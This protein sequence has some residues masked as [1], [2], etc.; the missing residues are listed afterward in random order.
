MPRSSKGLRQRSKKVRRSKKSRRSTRRKSFRGNDVY[1]AHAGAVVSDSVRQMAEKRG[2]TINT[3]FTFQKD[4]EHVDLP[5][6]HVAVPKIFKQSLYDGD[7]L[8]NTQCG[9]EED[10]YL[11]WERG[12]DNNKDETQCKKIKYL[13]CQIHRTKWDAIRWDR[14]IKDKGK[15]RFFNTGRNLKPVAARVAAPV[16]T[17]AEAELI[18]KILERSK[19]IASQYKRTQSEVED[20]WKIGT[21][22]DDLD[23]WE[24]NVRRIIERS[25]DIASQY[26]STPKIV[27]NKWNRE[28]D[29]DLDVWEVNV[30]RRMVLDKLDNFMRPNHLHLVDSNLLDVLD[31]R[32][33][34]DRIARFQALYDEAETFDA[35]RVNAFKN[36][37]KNLA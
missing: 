26:K 11:K 12:C 27:E 7:S 21:Y 8:W 20:I 37:L 5:P 15:V 4:G 33:N 18:D 22:D 10:E 1:T 25:I 14:I 23:K 34:I 30:R 13:P 29:D 17:R 19:A 32:G 24:A 36:H 35:D 6:G 28:Y 3:R 31:K 2:E 16:A 9:V